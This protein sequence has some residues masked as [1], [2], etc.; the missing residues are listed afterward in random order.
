MK[1]TSVPES[2]LGVNP[3]YGSGCSLID[4]Q[5]NADQKPPFRGFLSTIQNPFSYTA[6]VDAADVSASV[7]DWEDDSA[8]VGVL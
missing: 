7:A 3:I 6:S 5:I 1:S 4:T 2:S 8:V